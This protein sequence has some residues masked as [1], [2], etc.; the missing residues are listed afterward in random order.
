MRQSPFSFVVLTKR[1]VVPISYK[2]H[3]ESTC[4]LRNFPVRQEQSPD[5][6]VREALL[7]TLSSPLLF[8]PTS[9]KKDAATFE[10]VG[11][12][13]LISNPVRQVIAEAYATFGPERRVAALVSLGCGHPG[14]TSI[15]EN[16]DPSEWDKLL[17]KVV[18]NNEKDAQF[19]DAQMGH[20]GLY[21]RFSVNQGL[22]ISSE[23]PDKSQ[24]YTLT[25]TTVYLND[26]ALSEKL[27]HCLD[28]IKL[29]DGTSSLEQLSRFFISR[30]L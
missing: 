27:E 7:V 12:D 3:V 24:E 17:S 22:E 5:L 4:I 1:S 19:A 14:F 23:N 6:T 18:T 30:S 9:I 25:Q 2:R 20:L 11:G 26:G 16:S 29:Q 21:H 10:Y 28:S 15:P 8:L 13:L